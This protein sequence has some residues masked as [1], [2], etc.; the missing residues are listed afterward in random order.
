MGKNSN[1]GKEEGKGAKKDPNREV[2]WEEL[3]PACE[4]FQIKD[5]HGSVPHAGRAPTA[6]LAGEISAGAS[7]LVRQKERNHRREKKNKNGVLQERVAPSAKNAAS[8]ASAKEE[9][10]S[11]KSSMSW[12]FQLVT[13]CLQ[14]VYKLS[15]L[16]EFLRTFRRRLLFRPGR[17]P[18]KAQQLT[19][20]A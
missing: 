6:L 3:S 9:P 15:V 1:K 18:G 8:S 16:S 5:E 20:R 17:N 7:G 10:P 4:F 2:P 12:T 13:N 11:L 19:V 14:T